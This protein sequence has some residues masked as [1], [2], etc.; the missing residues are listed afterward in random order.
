M[1]FE[2]THHF[3]KA[4][5]RQDPLRSFRSK[6][7]IPTV[8]GKTALYFTGNSLGLQP[9][10][11]KRFLLEELE[12]WAALGVEGHVH[13]RR[14]WMYYHK[15]TK[16][17]LASVV[18][19]KPSEVVAMNQLTVN[20]HLML[21]S[22]YTP[23]PQRY[24]ILTESGAFSSDQYAFE[25]QLK[26]HGLDPDKALVEL[27]PREGEYTLRTD[28]I[29]AAIETHRD[30]LALVIFGGVQYYTGQFFDIPRITQ[31]G[32]RAGACVGFDLA[33][34]VGNVPLSLHKHDVDFAVWC[35]Y[36]YLNSG[37]GAIAGA[38]IHERHS[39]KFTGPR[40]AGWWGQVEKERFQMLK[41][42]KPM[43]GIDGWQL[44][45]VPIFQSAAHLAALEI[46]QDAGMKAVRAKSILL[47]GYLEFL[48]K[49]MDAGEKYFTLLTPS[50]PDER[51]AQ[52]SLLMK[53]DGKKIF[54]ALT[55]AGAIVDW[56]E[57]DVIR[58]APAPLYNS[59]EDVFQLG[60]LFKK[61]L[62]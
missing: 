20:L 10:T 48:L 18:G 32:K 53:K 54:K 9:K 14:P 29:L 26:F 42:F 2:N 51:G 47:T 52:L 60:L 35:S 40:L 12:D 41:G 39:K 25:S 1:T 24:K 27:K 50:S 44:S 21:I 7:H 22:F 23:T 6:F 16:K 43:E 59:F 15:L 56:R 45:N 17:A 11:T 37:P 30:E 4:M 46:F 55:K 31:A 19:A 49:E 13:A 33:H 36:K 3:A 38:F 8:H 28:D 5:D 58:L 62:K 61:A 34:A 57:P